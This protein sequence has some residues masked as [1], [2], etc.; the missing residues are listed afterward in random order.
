MISNRKTTLM[1]LLF[2]A[3]SLQA[4]AQDHFYYYNGTKIPLTLNEN[5]VIVSISKD[6]AA[7]TER[8]FT[9]VQPLDTIRDEIFDIYV[10]ARSDYETLTATETW[11]E[12]AKSV[13][14]TLCYYTERGK[15]LWA[16]PYLNV[17]L[18]KE[19]DIDLLTSYAEMYGL[20]IVRNS[21]FLPLW[22]ILAL[23]PES[24]MDSVECANRLYET[25]CF[26]ASQ[27]DLV[28]TVYVYD[29]GTTPVRS[30]ATTKESIGIYDLQGQRHESLPE[31]RSGGGRI[32]IVEGRKILVK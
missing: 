10:M 16:S 19:E 31:G 3:C 27:A 26:A 7:T 13:I 8:L 21:Q 17:R 18:K 32:Y 9:N 25:G 30:I 4:M 11:E 1:L 20:S 23:T 12:D 2:I 22:Y 6:C 14:L 15:E 29:D 5:K 28:A 24:G